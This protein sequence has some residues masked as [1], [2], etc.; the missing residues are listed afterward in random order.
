MLIYALISS[1]F[2]IFFGG[3]LPDAAVSGMIGIGIRCVELLLQPL[4]LNRFLLVVLLSTVSGCMA[5]SCVYTNAMFSLDKISIGNIM[6]LIPGLMFT[7]CIREMISENMLS[8]LT[9]FWKHYLFL[10]PSPLVLPLLT[11]CCKRRLVP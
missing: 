3:S 11:I 6:I 10:L 9:S 8:G 4:P 2:T 5:A 1:S 7:N